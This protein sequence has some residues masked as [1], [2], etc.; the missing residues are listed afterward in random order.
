MYEQRIEVARTYSRLARKALGLRNVPILTIDK[1]RQRNSFAKHPYLEIRIHSKEF[2]DA[3]ERCYPA[4][5]STEPRKTP[6]QMHRLDNRHL[7]FFLRGLFDAEGHARS[8]R[9]GIAMKSE[10]L[11]KQLQLLLMR[12]GIVSSYSHSVNRY[13]STMH[14]LDISDFGSLEVFYKSI[15][16]SAKDKERKLE[17]R[18]AKR[19]ARSSF[20]NVPV[21]GS[22]VDGRAKELGIRRREFP[23]IT[24]FFHDERGISRS[25]F[26]GVVRTCE[27]ELSRARSSND[28]SQRLALLQDT[29]SQ[30]RMIEQSELIHGKCIKGW[31]DRNMRR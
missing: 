13:G 1:T 6:E 7:A 23:G 15:G 24:N 21:I 10:T 18:G 4:E 22:W 3:L 28:S 25:V 14:A 31:M 16:F 29:V 30:L 9:I 5:T 2:A 26:S 8:K 19:R 20:L 12:F 17:R 11:I 27:D